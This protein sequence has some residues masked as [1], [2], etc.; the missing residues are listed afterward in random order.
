MGPFLIVAG[1]VTVIVGVLVSVNEG[2]PKSRTT[3]Q[4]AA[5]KTKTTESETPPA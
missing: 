4:P 2:K 3:S 1:M 5:P